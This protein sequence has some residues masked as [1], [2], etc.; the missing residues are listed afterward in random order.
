MN[1]IQLCK[2]ATG[3]SLNP[4]KNCASSCNLDFKEVY[5]Q[6]SWQIGDRPC[7]SP[8]TAVWRL[9]LRKKQEIVSLFTP[10]S[11]DFLEDRDNTTNTGTV[12]GLIIF[13]D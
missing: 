12:K 10:L 8:P 1:L 9:E 3:L 2:L 11:I 13:C 7:P 6:K 5:L 4:P